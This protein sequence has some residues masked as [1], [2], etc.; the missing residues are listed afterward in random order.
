MASSAEEPSMSLSTDVRAIVSRLR[1]EGRRTDAALVELLTAA[2]RRGELPDEPELAR[3]V[4]VAV[5]LCFVLAPQLRPTMLATVAMRC[6][7]VERGSATLDELADDLCLGLEPLAARATAALAELA[8]APTVALRARVLTE[9]AA[10]DA[11]LD[12]RVEAAVGGLA[13]SLA[14]SVAEADGD[15]EDGEDD[16]SDDEGQSEREARASFERGVARRRAGDVAGA[17]VDLGRAVALAPTRAD[18]LVERGVLR[19]EHGDHEGALEDLDAALAEEARH[20]GALRHRAETRTALGDH[21][22]ALVDLDALLEAEPASRDAL[23]ARGSA[24]AARGEHEAAVRDFDRALALDPLYASAHAKRALSTLLAEVTD[25]PSEVLAHAAAALACGRVGWAHAA[26]VRELLELALRAMREGGARAHAGPSMRVCASM[27]AAG[28]HE[29]ASGLADEL[30]RLVPELSLALRAVPRADP[31]AAAEA[32]AAEPRTPASAREQAAFAGSPRAPARRAERLVLFPPWQ[33]TIG[34]LRRSAQALGLRFERLHAA[35]PGAWLAFELRPTAAGPSGSTASMPLEAAMVIAEHSALDA[36]YLV[37]EGPEREAL[38]ARVAGPLELASLAELDA[39]A[40][41]ATDDE[42]WLFALRA[43]RLAREGDGGRGLALDGLA[44]PS[45][46]VRLEALATL[47]SLGATVLEEPELRGVLAGLS[48]H[49]PDARVRNLSKSS[50]GEPVELEIVCDQTISR[51]L[52]RTRRGGDVTL[53]RALAGLLFDAGCFLFEV[54]GASASRPREEIWL[55]GDGRNVVLATEDDVLG[56]T[57]VEVRGAGGDQLTETLARELGLDDT[58]RAL[59]EAEG[60]P[61][62][63][64]A[65]EVLS[66]LL[67]LRPEREHE[68]LGRALGAF[69]LC[70]EPSVRALALEACAMTR[71]PTL[72]PFVRAMAEREPRAELRAQAARLFEELCATG[73]ASP[74]VEPAPGEVRERPRRGVWL[75]AHQPG[76]QAA[77]RVEAV[78]EA[79]LERGFVIADVARGPD[80]RRPVASLERLDVDARV[81]VSLGLFSVTLACVEGERELEVGEGLLEPHRALSFVDLATLTRTFAHTHEEG[82]ARALLRAWAALAGALGEAREH[83]LLRVALAR[84]EEAVRLEAV[85]LAIELGPA[86]LKAELEAARALDPSAD[87]RRW[88]ARALAT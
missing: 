2:L 46:R 65:G 80:D 9:L 69:V 32:A 82:E 81:A 13:A 16:E 5:H 49:D 34:E 39:S 58:E 3:A 54:H 7:L 40:R 11:E 33:S 83:E 74:D 50:L 87:V 61:E 57:R 29:L 6:D 12:A 30:S 56:V 21:A 19:L 28:A 52:V 10:L 60:A 35:S 68:R 1:D 44:H 43:S 76:S 53:R 4:L 41:G 55:G 59:A 48:R 77:P 71:W 22:G 25:W 36:R 63:D 73:L 17:L 84:E 24:K 15:D 38:A 79:L 78:L 31:R 23:V 62:S 51:A 47:A 85:R 18:Y 67:A 27:S 86:H 64:R 45:P 66:K 37:L 20:T 70:P 42:P 8:A 88:A 75:A 14:G 26:P 72:A